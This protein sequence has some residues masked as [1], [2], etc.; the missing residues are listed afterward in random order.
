MGFFYWV[1]DTYFPNV[2]MLFYGSGVIYYSNFLFIIR[3]VLRICNY[4]YILI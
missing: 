4:N 2:Y 1:Q 3:N